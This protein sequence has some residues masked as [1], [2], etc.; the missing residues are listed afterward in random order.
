[1]KLK[2]SR[3]KKIKEKR[4]AFVIAAVA[5]NKDEAKHANL[6]ISTTLQ[7]VASLTRFLLCLNK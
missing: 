4:E 2:R 6:I 5:I 7:S 1:M 3:C